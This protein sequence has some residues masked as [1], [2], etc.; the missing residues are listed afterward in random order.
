MDIRT[1]RAGD[2]AAV[3]ALWEEADTEPSHTDDV[4]SLERLVAHD[5]GA[6]IV[7]EDE[8]RIIGT[9]VA[10]WDGWRGSIYRLAVAPGYRRQGVGAD[11]LT[12]AEARLAHNAP[13]RLQAIVVESD[14]QA[15][16]FWC[17]APGWE[18]QVDRVRF[19][20]G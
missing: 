14:P 17:A 11:L 12:A 3:L 6:L 13:A 19:T 20:K 15:L 7:M 10:A 18:R 16:S 4:P 2:A 8:G 1:A 5:P 9:V